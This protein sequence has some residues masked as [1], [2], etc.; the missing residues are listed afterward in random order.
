M[1][2]DYGLADVRVAL[3]HSGASDW[4]GVIRWLRQGGGANV[5]QGSAQKMANDMEVARSRGL[6]FQPDP[7]AVLNAAERTRTGAGGLEA[8]RAG[9]AEV[10]PGD[11]EDRAEVHPDDA[12]GL[13]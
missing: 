12:E 4:E 1:P 8:A 3:E 10:W 9:E 6:P 5:L 13:Q 11:E 7:E 2:Q